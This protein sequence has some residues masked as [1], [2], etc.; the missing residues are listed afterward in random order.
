MKNNS[1]PIVSIG[2]MKLYLVIPAVFLLLAGSLHL[3]N[4]PN[5]KGLSYLAYLNTYRTWAPLMIVVWIA[6][7]GGIYISVLVTINI[8]TRG[9][10]SLYRSDDYVIFIHQWWSRSKINDVKGIVVSPFK[11]WPFT[12]TMVCLERRNAGVTFLSISFM[13]EPNAEI[14]SKLEKITGIK[15]V[16]QDIF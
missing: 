14:I 5:S 8:L 12:L 9:G 7:I 2:K 15:S 1:P 11:I 13:R 6:S 16:Q 4:L 10:T 3:L